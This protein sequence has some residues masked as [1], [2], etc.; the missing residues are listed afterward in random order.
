MAD[1]DTNINITLKNAIAATSSKQGSMQ[2][3]QHTIQQGKNQPQQISI[4]DII[5]QFTQLKQVINN[6]NQSNKSTLDKLQK[7]LQTLIDLQ[8]QQKTALNKVNTAL[9]NKD[10]E[11]QSTKQF[12]D[13]AFLERIKEFFDSLKTE[14]LII[15]ENINN[16]LN[17]QEQTQDFSAISESIQQSVLPITEKLQLLLQKQENNNNTDII[18][19]LTQIKNT[20][21]SNTDKAIDLSEITLHLAQIKSKLEENSQISQAQQL[22]ILI[23]NAKEIRH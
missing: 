4:K 16:A 18:S 12:D 6:A 3:P 11:K 14:L 10:K 21:S 22:N 8:S 17:K 20:L 9:Q 2:S 19:E 7:N 1:K 13:S 23:Q 15:K 5:T